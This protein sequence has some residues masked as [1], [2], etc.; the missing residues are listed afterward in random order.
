MEE[1]EFP[2]NSYTLIVTK[3]CRFANPLTY[4]DYPE[5]MKAIVGHRLPRFTKEESALVK[6]SIDFLG[7]NYYTT[8]YAANNP[9]PNKINFSYTGDSQTILSSKLRK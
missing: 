2:N 6:G 8:N 1:M 5:T 9:A 7:V 4:G 3:L